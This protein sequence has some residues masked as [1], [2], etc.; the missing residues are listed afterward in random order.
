MQARILTVRSAV[1]VNTLHCFRNS[2]RPKF[3]ATSHIAIRTASS[4]RNQ[5]GV[6][7]SCA[8]CFSSRDTDVAMGGNHQLISQR[9]TAGRRRD[10]WRPRF[11]GPAVGRRL[12]PL[13]EHRHNRAVLGSATKMRKKASAIMMRMLRPRRSWTRLPPRSLRTDS[14]VYVGSHAA[15]RNPTAD[16]ERWR[17]RHRPW[18]TPSPNW[19][20]W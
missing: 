19:G 16:G 18:D 17:I 12:D 14:K 9:P 10:G 4:R 20:N 6:M 15:W 11:V 13:H 3:P 1:S 5:R 7:H 2:P 8:A